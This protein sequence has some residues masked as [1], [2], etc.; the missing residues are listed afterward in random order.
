MQLDFYADP[1]HGWLAVPVALL[2]RLDLLD[3]ITSYS[4][5][6]GKT[7]YLEEDGD[8]STFAAAARAAGLAYT[9]RE[10]VARERRSRIRGYCH[11][12]MEAALHA[13][14]RPGPLLR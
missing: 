12:S 3:R 2:A 14:D 1:G 11:Y 10:R 4:Y 6:R 5:I 8:Y 7:A 13:M 9:V